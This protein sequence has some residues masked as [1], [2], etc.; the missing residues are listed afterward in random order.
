MPIDL[1]YVE[2][3]A[4][5]LLDIPLATNNQIVKECFT[6]SSNIGRSWLEYLL[7]VVCLDVGTIFVK[8]FLLE[9]V[10]PGYGHTCEIMQP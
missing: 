10:L 5:N 8:S 1:R 7:N 6:T 9:L 3:K 2:R 4:T